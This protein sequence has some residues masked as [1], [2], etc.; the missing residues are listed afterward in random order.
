MICIRLEGGLG[1]QLFQYAAGRSLAIRHKTNLVLDI[2]ILKKIRK[3]ITFREM[4][5]NHFKIVAEIADAKSIKYSQLFRYA[6][7][8][9]SF[10]T[11]WRPFIENSLNFNSNFAN[12]PNSTYL[13]GYWQSFR[14]F[15][16]IASLIYSELMPNRPM[17]VMS[18]ALKSEMTE[19]N[20]VAL[21][22]RR[23]DYVTLKSANSMHGALSV[24]Y[25]KIAID[26]IQ[27][28]LVNPV[29]YVFSDDPTWCRDN[30][31]LPLNSTLY[32][33]H[34]VGGDSWQDLILM[35]HCQHTVIANSSFSWWA[36]WL[37]DQR[38]GLE[39]RLVYAPARWFVGT[40]HDTKDRFP[41]HWITK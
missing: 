30:L 8:A 4:E 17:S 25:Y 16:D 20:S 15:D 38:Y 7:G 13:V 33:S 19:V 14:Y 32:V 18:S 37:A 5:L 11:N 29:F 24:S 23:G 1:N 28:K 6:P 39:N 34:N 31:P 22:V 9:T 2:S 10:F 27:A 12:L 3:G 21:H 26:D 40:T 35:S 36:A 41:C